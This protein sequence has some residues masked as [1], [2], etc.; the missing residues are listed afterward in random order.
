[1]LTV[2][3]D[4]SLGNATRRKVLANGSDDERRVERWK[5]AVVLDTVG[6]GGGLIEDTLHT[7]DI[8][9]ELTDARAGGIL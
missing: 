4:A 9:R 6:H 2:V 5:R 1:M 8:A 7:L 3:P